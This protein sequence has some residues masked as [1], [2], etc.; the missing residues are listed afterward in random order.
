MASSFF[1]FPVD[2]IADIRLYH[3]PRKKPLPLR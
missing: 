3:H 1:V 2:A